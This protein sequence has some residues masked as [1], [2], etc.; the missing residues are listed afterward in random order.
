MNTVLYSFL[1]EITLEQPVYEEEE[2]YEMEQNVPEEFNEN[3]AEELPLYEDDE[4]IAEVEI[5]FS[6]L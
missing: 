2:V 1:D 6:E 5:N 3:E 4:E